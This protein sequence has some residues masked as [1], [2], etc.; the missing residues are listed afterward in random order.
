MIR[1]ATKDSLFI[2]YNEL[3]K[4]LKGISPKL[5]TY[6]KIKKQMEEIE[7]V[8]NNINNQNG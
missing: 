6:Q 7:K 8:L 2:Q 5:S 1:N 3:E 4:Q